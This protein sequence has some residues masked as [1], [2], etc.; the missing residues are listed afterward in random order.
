MDG[1]TV[2]RVVHYVEGH[3]PGNHLAALV[4]YVWN[5]DDGLINLGGVDSNGEPFRKTS[6]RFSEGAEPNTWHWIE[7]A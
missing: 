1:L 3:F 6:V 5:K 2:G 4:A 7:R